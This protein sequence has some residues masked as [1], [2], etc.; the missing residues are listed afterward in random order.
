[1]ILTFRHG[2]RRRGA[3]RRLV[4]DDDAWIIFTSGSTGKPKGEAITHR[5]AVEGTCDLAAVRSRLAETLPAALVPLLAVVDAI[6][7]RTSGKVD[8][9]ALPWPLP[10]AGGADGRADAVQRARR[11]SVGPA[12]GGPRRGRLARLSGVDCPDSGSPPRPIASVLV[13]ADARGRSRRRLTTR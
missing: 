1:M 4:P 13:R 6:P 9:A 7:T 10:G 5:S 8:R 2:V 11:R 12:A 3:R